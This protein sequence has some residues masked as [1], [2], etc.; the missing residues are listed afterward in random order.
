MNR[1]E[2]LDSLKLYLES[3]DRLPEDALRQGVSLYEM[4]TIMQI[5]LE[6]LDEK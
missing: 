5:V 4:R 3:I 1:E 2:K 6:L